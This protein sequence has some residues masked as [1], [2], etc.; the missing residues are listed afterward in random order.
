MS[1]VHTR[2]DITGAGHLADAGELGGLGG[3]LVKHV[4]HEGVEAAHGL[5]GDAS[6]G[7]D[8]MQQKYQTSGVRL[9]TVFSESST[10]RG[11]RVSHQPRVG[12]QAH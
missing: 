6:V 4:V 3:D 1:F 7:V 5:G 9:H 8:L 12:D 11:K 2:N 10:C